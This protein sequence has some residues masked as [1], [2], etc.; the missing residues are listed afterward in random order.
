MPAERSCFAR[1]SGRAKALVAAGLA[2][3][4]A[5]SPSMATSVDPRLAVVVVVGPPAGACPMS[6][7]DGARTGRTV[8]RLP[9]KPRVL[10]RSTMRSGIAF[11]SVAV[12]RRGAT[13]VVGA[14]TPEIA[15]F[16]ADGREQWRAKTGNQ[17][18]LVGP[19]ILSD[20]TRVVVTGAGEA[21]GFDPNGGRRFTTDLGSPG[22]NARAAPLPLDDGGAAVAA[23]TEIVFLSADGQVQGRS[24]IGES[25]AG[26]LVQTGNGVAVTTEK[27]NVYLASPAA[28]ARR[29]GTLGGSPGPGAAATDERTLLAVVDHTRIVAFDVR[30]G[31][32][33]TLRAAPNPQLDGPAALGSGKTVLLTTFSGV[34]VGVSPDGTEVRRAALDAGAISPITDAGTI[35]LAAMSESPPLLVDASG[36]VGFARVGGRIGVVAPDGSVSTVEQSGCALPVAL[37]PAGAARMVAACRDGSILMVGEAKTP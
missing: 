16:A 11:G 27:G 20:E 25:A 28:S 1:P 6:R 24:Q 8:D 36:R 23:G 5:E 17:S 31:A 21:V 14:A 29:V 26:A 22:K 33:Q 37:A 7:I 15:Q 13:I 32:V 12:D 10:W 30:T 34:M 4:V 35:N 18:P 9:E 2:A 19:V 3:V